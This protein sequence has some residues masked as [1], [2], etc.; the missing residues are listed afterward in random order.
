MEITLASIMNSV[1]KP[2]MPLAH[3]LKPEASA[4]ASDT[5]IQVAIKPFWLLGFHLPIMFIE[6]S[7]ARDNI[8]IYVKLRT[9]S[10]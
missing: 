2:Q 9:H 10:V 5:M 4:T 6:G 3:I 1:L 7:L 8:I